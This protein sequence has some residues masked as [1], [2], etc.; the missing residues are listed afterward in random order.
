MLQGVKDGAAGG[1]GGGMPEVE[2]QQIACGDF[3]TVG[4]TPTG[5]LYA[6]GRGA[7]GQLGHGH[8]G[9]IDKP[10]LVTCLTGKKVVHAAC[11]NCHT[12][13]VT[14]EGELHTWY[15]YKVHQYKVD[16]TCLARFNTK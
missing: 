13:A 3:H 7:W 6:W 10:K 2:W 4:V 1:G 15:V 16:F 9:T 8:E 14:S 11:G 12:A 5:E